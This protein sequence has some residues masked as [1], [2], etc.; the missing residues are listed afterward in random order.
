MILLYDIYAKS[1]LYGPLVMGLCRLLNVLLGAS[2]ADSLLERSDP[3]MWAIGIGIYTI[4]L[5][6]I[7]RREATASHSGEL[8]AGGVLVGGGMI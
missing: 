5:T 8:I 1:T 4:G 6:L 7:A 3:I 2:V